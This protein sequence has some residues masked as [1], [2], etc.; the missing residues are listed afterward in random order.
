MT[1]ALVAEASA[2]QAAKKR[3][4]EKRA[5]DAGRDGPEGCGRLKIWKRASLREGSPLTVT[6]SEKTEDGRW[7]KR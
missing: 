4:W 2:G 7:C 5:V 6:G 3:F 1:S